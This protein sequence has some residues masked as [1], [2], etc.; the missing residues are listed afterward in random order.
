LVA[1]VHENLD[2]CEHPN[3][4]KNEVSQESG[5]SWKKVGILIATTGKIFFFV[6]P[7]ISG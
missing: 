7:Y 6:K 3:S 5:F 4:H 2:A 1:K